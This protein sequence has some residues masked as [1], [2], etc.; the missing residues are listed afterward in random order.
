MYFI[1]RVA[2]LVVGC[3]GAFDDFRNSRL[4]AELVIPQPSLGALVSRRYHN[5]K[6]L[7]TSIMKIFERR[8]TCL[9]S[10]HCVFF[11]SSIILVVKEVLHGSITDAAKRFSAYDLSCSTSAT[12]SVYHWGECLLP[13]FSSEP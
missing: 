1:L 11:F 7:I 9:L 3:D 13:L 10:M 8:I 2:V 12:A 4:W 5:G 6:L